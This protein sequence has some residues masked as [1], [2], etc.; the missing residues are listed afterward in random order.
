MKRA[1]PS[2]CTF[3][4]RKTNEKAFGKFLQGR[5]RDLPLGERRRGGGSEENEP[6]DRQTELASDS[7]IKGTRP[8]Q[9]QQPKR[10]R[11]KQCAYTH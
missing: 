2:S 6:K 11:L 1:T 8:L 3:C 4:E 7:S 5:E 10:R 9:Q